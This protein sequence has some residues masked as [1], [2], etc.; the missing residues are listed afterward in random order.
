VTGLRNVAAL[1]RKEWHHYFG[2]PIAWVVL[3][4]WTLLFGIFFYYGLSFFVERSGPGGPMQMGG[5]PMSLNEWVVAP[6]LQNMAVVALFLAPMLTMRL[7]AEE[8]RQGTIEL[9]STSPLTDFQI[10][11]GKFLAAV[12]VYALMVLAALLNVVMLWHY[13]TVNPEWRPVLTGALAVLLC[14][15]SFMALGTFVSTLTRNQIVAATIT[16]GLA[17]VMWT[18]SWIN[19]PTAGVVTQA[20]AYLG[21]TNHLEEMVKGVLA[22]KDLV[23]YLTVIAFG[24]FLTHQSV[25][26]QRWRA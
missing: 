3:F 5:P 10:V 19:D 16:F 23:F 9:L 13:A 17:L 18:L 1:V 8:K 7:F 2:S 26:S 20:V 12:G 14:G 22:V 25:Q 21:V 4:V 6:V 11:M 24:L 15:A